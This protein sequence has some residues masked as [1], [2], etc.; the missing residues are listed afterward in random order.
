MLAVP[1]SGRFFL[2]TDD[3]AVWALISTVLTIGLVLDFGAPTL[4]TRLGVRGEA[5]RS[6]ILVICAVSAS[7]TL[8]SGLAS[9]AAWPLLTANIPLA[10]STVWTQYAVLVLVMTGAGLRS[11]SAV[12]AAVALGQGKLRLRAVSIVLSALLQFTTTVVA[13]VLGAGIWALAVGLLIGSIATLCY[14]W[15]KLTFSTADGAGAVP[16]RPLLFR[17][18]RTKGIGTLAGLLVNQLDRWVLAIV[19]SPAVLSSYDVAARLASAP[20][21]LAIALAAGIAAQA[22]SPDETLEDFAAHLR[23]TTVLSAV[24]MI[25]VDALVALV[26]LGAELLGILATSSLFWMLFVLL[27]TAHLVNGLT[28]A[29]TTALN[30]L[31]KPQVELRYLVAVLCLAVV[32]YGMSLLLTDQYLP[33]IAVFVSLTFPGGLFVLRQR[34]LLKLS[35]ESS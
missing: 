34:R 17:F 23:R 31:G 8:L 18:I 27:A 11:V 2:R 16:V 21:V 15:P 6:R 7:G 32:G 20:K 25:V 35:W 33:A 4:A 1:L 24:V 9:I 28:A 26:L 30:A 5:T 12:L 13:L 29:G 19:A 3:Y 14:L 22:V 10:T